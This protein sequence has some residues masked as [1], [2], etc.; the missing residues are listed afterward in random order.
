MPSARSLLK[1]DIA[2]ASSWALAI[3]SSLGAHFVEFGSLL[4]LLRRPFVVDIAAVSVEAFPIPN[5]P[6]LGHIGLVVERVLVPGGV[7]S[8][9]MSANW[10]LV[11]LLPP[12]MLVLV[13][14]ILDAAAPVTS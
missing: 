5:V 11:Q 1:D 3:M 7:A 8:V 6:S 12:L 2:K 13:P 10:R 9:F 4:L 14:L